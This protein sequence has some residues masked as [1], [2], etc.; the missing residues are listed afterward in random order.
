[1]SDSDEAAVEGFLFRNLRISVEGVPLAPMRAL[2]LLHVWEQVSFDFYFSVS[3]F[4]TCSSKQ[5]CFCIRYFLLAEHQ[6]NAL[7]K[8]KIASG[9]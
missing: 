3:C 6:R 2:L 8:V 4:Q 9:G 1:M 7:T 5:V